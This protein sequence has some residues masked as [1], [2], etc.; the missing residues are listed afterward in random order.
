VPGRVIFPLY[1]YLA[2]KRDFGKVP[3]E[4]VKNIFSGTKKYPEG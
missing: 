3:A 4:K 2:G 1:N